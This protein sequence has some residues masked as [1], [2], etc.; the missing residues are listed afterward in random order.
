MTNVLIAGYYGAGNLGDEAILLCMLRELKRT[1]PGFEPMIVSMDPESTQRLHGVRAVGYQ[2][3]PALIEAARTSKLIILGG[4]GLFHDYWAVDPGSV[5]TREQSGMAYYAGIP[6]L[7]RL[8]GVP[9]MIYAV[10]V[11]PL[12]TEASQQLTTMAFE[13]AGSAT[14]RDAPSLNLVRSLSGL[15][16]QAKA[17]VSIS[18]DPAFLL[19]ASAEAEI[20]AWLQQLGIAPQAEILAVVPRTWNRGEFAPTWETDLAHGLD[21]Y[22][23]GR[24]TVAVFIPFQTSPLSAE[25]DDCEACRRV[26]EAMHKTDRVALCPVAS[27]PGMVAGVLRRSKA[28]LAVRMHAALLALAGGTPVVALAYDAKVT[29]LFDR[30]G[31]GR[32]AIPAQ[33][34][35]AEFIEAAL[36]RAVQ[37]ALPNDLGSR[38]REASAASS[39]DAGIAARCMSASVDPSPV[40]DEQVRAFAVRELVQM[41]KLQNQITSL[42]GLRSQRDTLILH[43]NSLEREL[44]ELRSTLGFRALGAYWDLLRDVA[45][46]GTRRRELYQLMI[47]ALR[48]ASVSIGPSWATPAASEQWSGENRARLPSGVRAGSLRG[49]STDP[50]LELARFNDRVEQSDS[51]WI[52]AIFSTTQLVA[53]EG[54]RMT[55]LATEMARRGIPVVFAYWRWDESEWTTQERLA[56]GILQ[57]PIDT[58]LAH[59][60]ELAESFRGKE[61]IGLIEFPYPGFFGLL[62]WMHSTGWIVIYE[63]IDNWEG[64]AGVGMSPWYDKSFE[65]HIANGADLV[66]AVNPWLATRIGTLGRKDVCIVPNGVLRGI[67]HIDSEI[68]VDR[69]EITVGYFGH[70]TKAW[71]DWDLLLEAARRQ[72]TWRFHII[73]YGMEPLK[74]VIPP[75]VKLLGRVPQNRLAA[76]AANWDVGIVPFKPGPVADGTDAT[77]VYEYMA[78]GLPVVITGA[79]PPQGAESL[80]FRGTDVGTFIALIREASSTRASGH[81]ERRAFAANATWGH[82]VDEILEAVRG[83]H[84]RVGE[85]RA[86]RLGAA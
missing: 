73:G 2:D 3:I 65:A 58:V 75:N 82:R 40:A 23:A 71:V 7:A 14:V 17:R 11:G 20:D 80:V 21:A 18:A 9:C 81:H 43:R 41:A 13:L 86:M 46:E 62:A 68:Y 22:L 28:V 19:Q 78:M 31:V 8:V 42:E 36:D 64:F 45:P 51:P 34:I 52:A 25:D 77:K 33:A 1:I 12:R 61:R 35:S 6:L 54:Q 70:L 48:N 27:P 38:L 60:Q 10:G 85:K 69:G 74:K 84:Q 53:S 37:E 24:D 63:A 66:T 39:N 67:E 5:L 55:H 76:Y 59:P 79:Y 16:A 30:L 32:A 26:M 44:L 57:I 83:G 56:E 29:S 72:P 15:S 47:G 49:P 50:R 4:G